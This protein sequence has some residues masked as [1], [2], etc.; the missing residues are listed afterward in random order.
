MKDLSLQEEFDPAAARAFLKSVQGRGRT[1]FSWEDDPVPL[2]VKPSQSQAMPAYYRALYKY[3]TA[4]AID[5]VCRALVTLPLMRGLLEADPSLARIPIYID[6]LEDANFGSYHLDSGSVTLSPRVFSSFGEWEEDDS[7]E[8]SIEIRAIRTLGHEL[9]HAWQHNSGLF[10]LSWE[11]A[12]SP[13]YA[14]YCVLNNRVLEADANA[15]DIALLHDMGI[16]ADEIGLP[17]ENLYSSAHEVAI[18]CLE[19]YYNSI[20]GDEINHWNGR[21]M[22]DAFMAFF[23]L[24]NDQYVNLYDK[25]FARSLCNADPARIDSWDYPEFLMDHGGWDLF[26]QHIRRFGSVSSDEDGLIE[27]F[28]YL[29]EGAVDLKRKVLASSLLPA[30]LQDCGCTIGRKLPG[31]RAE[32]HFMEI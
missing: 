29:A 1:L 19:A 17:I 13:F 12:E 14:L 20:D 10:E 27:R 26:T 4:K 28:D 9:R 7:N 30:V 3:H 16:K 15:F 5:D 21:A 11:F 25:A 23:S 32:A 18:V 22:N 2:P 6:D 8:N 24:E 31:P